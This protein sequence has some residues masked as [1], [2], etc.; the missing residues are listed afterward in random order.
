MLKWIA[1]KYRH[2]KSGHVVTTMYE[3]KMQTSVP[4]GDMTPVI[5]YSHDNNVW[6]RPVNEFCDGRFELEQKNNKYLC[7][8]EVEQTEGE[9][10]PRCGANYDD[11]CGGYWKNRAR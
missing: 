5:V 4:V 9:S 2:L 6:V 3:A 1:D 11:L 10:C 8:D 7:D